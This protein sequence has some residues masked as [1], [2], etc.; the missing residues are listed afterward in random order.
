MI[1]IFLRSRKGRINCSV[2]TKK[3]SISADDLAA[4]NYIANP[5]KTDNGRLILRIIVEGEAEIHDRCV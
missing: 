2:P 4:L 3:F 5:E 1:T